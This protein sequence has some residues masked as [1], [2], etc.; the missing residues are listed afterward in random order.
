[1]S[2]M[3][4]RLPATII[5]ARRRISIAV[6]IIGILR[7]ADDNTVILLLWAPE[8]NPGITLVLANINIE[9]EGAVIFVVFAFHDQI[10]YSIFTGI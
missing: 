2:I 8:C 10:G 3:K 5:A 7:T 1:M 4:K 6:Y 9:N